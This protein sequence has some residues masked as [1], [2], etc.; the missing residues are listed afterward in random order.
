MNEVNKDTMQILCNRRKQKNRAD[1]ICNFAT[2]IIQLDYCIGHSYFV[3]GDGETCTDELLRDIV[4]Y[5]ILPMLQE[6]WFDD[7][8]KYQ[9]WADKLHKAVS[10]GIE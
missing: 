4:N 5:D 9:E 2:E 7:A 3:L 10:D 1:F 8:K 6:Y